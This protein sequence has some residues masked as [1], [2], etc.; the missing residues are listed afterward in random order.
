MQMQDTPLSAPVRSA[1]VLLALLQGLLMYAALE[2]AADWNI[3]VRYGWYA[4]VLAIPSAIALTL[5][6]L[7]DRRLWAHAAVGSLLVLAPAVWVAWNLQGESGLSTGGLQAPLSICIGIAVFIMLPWWQF[8]L[9]HGHWRADYGSLFERAWQNGLTL[10]L[11]A[12]FTGITWM[13]LWLL[14]GL[15]SMVQVKLFA[16]LFATRGFIAL[17]TGCLVGFGVLLGRTQHRAIQVTRQVLFALCR[18][19]LPLLSLIVLLFVLALPFTGLEPLWATRSA[20]SLLLVVVLL[21]VSFVNAVYQH[22]DARPPYPQWLRWAV[23]A[24][25]VALPV[26]AALALVAMSLRI[27]QYGW[28]L[29]RFWGFTVAVIAAG[30]ALGYALAA[31]RRQGRWLAALEPVN[32]LMCWVVLGAALLTNL[33]GLDPS[34]IATASQVERLRKAPAEMTASDVRTLRFDLGRAGVAGL[35]TLQNDPAIAADLRA[36]SMVKQALASKERYAPYAGIDEGARDLDGVKAAIML[37]KNRPAPAADWWQ[38]LLDRDLDAG[39]C[40][41]GDSD[42]VALR[43]DLDGD[44]QDE[45]LLCTAGEYMGA[46]CRLHVRDTDGW[47]QA[48]MVNFSGNST[49]EN[50]RAVSAVRNGE[51]TLSRPRWPAMTSGGVDARIDED[52]EY[53][54]G[55]TGEAEK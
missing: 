48:G 46:Y 7:T 20:A 6:D 44:G 31:L 23:Q 45:V 24:S 3:A 26:Y 54:R 47:K 42:C 49:E 34:R 28:T 39:S 13:L 25:L 33:P 50:R 40:L 38:A 41:D 29:G 51:L 53:L 27:S 11:A 55:R 30:Y 16:D 14:A 35:R 52:R 4:W 32:R 19:L 5:V 43:A 36:A 9:Q 15:F 17:A 18:G 1:I 2:L 10:V 22:D 37:A 21:L 12:A 8:R